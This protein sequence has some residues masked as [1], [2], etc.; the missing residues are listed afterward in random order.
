M[1][2][3]Q[4]YLKYKAKYL[5]LKAELEGGLLFRKNTVTSPVAKPE[6]KS[7]N[8]SEFIIKQ[9]QNIKNN[10]KKMEDDRKIKI[11]IITNLKKILNDAYVAEHIQNKGPQNTKNVE[12]QIKNIENETKKIIMTVIKEKIKI[13]KLEEQLKTNKK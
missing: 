1:N 12:E 6:V 7:D 8:N 4:K 10:I 11:K 5:A 2:Y 13:D 3:E 9:I